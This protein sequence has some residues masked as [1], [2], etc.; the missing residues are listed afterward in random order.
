LIKRKTTG[1]KR[2]GSLFNRDGSD[3]IK[4]SFQGEHRL[5]FQYSFILLHGIL[6][7]SIFL[8]GCRYTAPQVVQREAPLQVHFIDVGQGD[9]VLIISPQGKAALIDGGEARSGALQYLRGQ[10]V[11]QLDLVVATHPHD[12][13]IG[14]LPE[15]LSA[16]PTLRV[17]TNGQLSSTISYEK[18]LDAV[19]DNKAEYLEVKRGDRLSFGDLSF[20][21]LHP[22]QTLEDNPNNNSIVLRL[23]YGR[24]S[25]LFTGDAEKDAEH[26][27]I[28]S[29]QKL[30][31]TILKV[32]HHGS[33]LSTSPEFLDLVEP[34]AAVYF[35][36]TGNLYEHPHPE[37]LAALREKGVIVFGTDVNGTIELTTDGETYKISDSSSASLF[38]LPGVI[39]FQEASADD[40]VF[41]TSWYGAAMKERTIR[42]DFMDMVRR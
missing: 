41:P 2:P 11:R 18:L 34:E 25:L 19:I 28:A 15:I 23:E 4:P 5:K 13:H 3:T 37:T 29:Q 36:K 30:K 9:A 7:A 31:A 16:I 27:M 40:L 14:G 12:D 22:G 32:G 17:A 38:E 8:S 10:G 24:I 1:L 6:A 33:R 39:S 26:S 42:F 21:V 35:A 20:D